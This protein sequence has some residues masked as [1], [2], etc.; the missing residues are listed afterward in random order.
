MPNYDYM[1]IDPMVVPACTLGPCFERF[2]SMSAT[3]L[4]TCEICDGPVERLVG[5]GAA[6]IFK[7][8]GFQ[9]K[10]PVPPLESKT[11]EVESKTVE[12]NSSDK[13]ELVEPVLAVESVSKTVESTVELSK[14]V[15]SEP[16]KLATGDL[17]F[18]SE[19]FTSPIYTSL[20]IFSTT[21]TTPNEE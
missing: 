21:S 11:V 6:V 13:V 8:E 7:G 19:L 2:E 12:S 9:T 17:N 4:S 5:A 18:S 20:P 10:Q 3:R 14:M 15:E 1:H 16:A